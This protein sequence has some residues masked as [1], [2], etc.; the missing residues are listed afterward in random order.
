[1]KTNIAVIRFRI[2]TGFG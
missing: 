2:W 1:M